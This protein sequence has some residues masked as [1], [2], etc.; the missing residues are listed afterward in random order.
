MLRKW[1][2][3]FAFDARLLDEAGDGKDGSGGTGGQKDGGANG[4]GDGTGDQ[5][6]GGE[7]QGEGDKKT[8]KKFEELDPEA[9]K[10]IKDLR[11]ENA[12]LRNRSKLSEDTAAKLKKSLI[13][14]GVIEADDEDP[15]EKV[16]GLSM[17][18]AGTEQRAAI[19][20]AALDHSVPKA[21]VEFFEF[22]VQKKMSS[23]QEGEELTDDDLAALAIEAKKQTGVAP[24]KSGLGNKGGSGTPPP[25]DKGGAGGNDLTA[26]KFAKMSMAEKSALYAKDPDAYK[27]LFT[28]A[29]TARL[30]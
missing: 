19:L 17:Q 27:R 24:E 6:S 26:Q 15:T 25:Q 23:L 5:N 2:Q 12:G 9:Q 13:E 16:K 20:E 3:N 28:E 22:L 11:K 14:A 18:L 1:Q 8:G 29:K 10:I 30:L 4:G 21:S 7:C